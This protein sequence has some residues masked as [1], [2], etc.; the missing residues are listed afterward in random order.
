MDKKTILLKAYDCDSGREAIEAAGRILREGGI[1]AIPT[2]TVYGLAGNALDP[3]ATAKIYE[4]KGRP[5][6]NPLI[7]HIAAWEE[8]A[9]LVRRVPREAELLAAAFWPGPLTMILPKAPL[10]P[11]TTSGGLDTVAVRMPRDPVARGIIRA[12]GV[13]LAAPSANRSGSPSPTTWRHCVDDL[14]GRVDAIVES[15]DCQVGVEST[16]I[17]LCPGPDG[18]TQ[19]RLLRPGA[20]TLEQLREVLG[21][22]A[23]DQGV[24]ERL[25]EGAVVHSP[26]MKYK[27][28]APAADVILVKGSSAAYGEYLKEHRAPG[29]YAMCFEEDLP[30]AGEPALSYGAAADHA[31]QAARLFD[32]LRELDRLGAKRVYVHAPQV[33]GVGLAVYNRLIRAAGFQIVE[34]EEKTEIQP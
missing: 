8:L 17:S 6:D 29:E 20:V 7:V 12:A 24:L 9:P 22:V 32:L 26:G 1:A 23:V 30:L 25:P 16:V 10:V 5:S 15:H 28:Y 18:K 13:P 11:D 3:A 2:E 4:A 21:E 14:W 33:D 19:S 31:A 27:H 34:A